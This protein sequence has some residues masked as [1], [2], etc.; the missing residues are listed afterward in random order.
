MFLTTDEL[1][2]LV[3]RC[4]GLQSIVHL[5]DELRIQHSISDGI[6]LKY[7]F[8]WV[9]Y[10]LMKQGRLD[11]LGESWVRDGADDNAP[12]MFGDQPFSPDDVVING[13]KQPIDSN[14]EGVVRLIES[15]WPH[16]IVA[17]FNIHDQGF[18]PIWFE[19]WCFAWHN[20]IGKQ[21]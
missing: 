9:V 2:A 11:F 1:E 21:I 8:L 3:Y 5:Y 19:K 12:F 20:K 4:E 14:P 15:K 13:L 18:D 6:K 10:E 16:Q 17:A 7:L